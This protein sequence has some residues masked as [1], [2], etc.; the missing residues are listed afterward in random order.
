MGDLIERRDEALEQARSAGTPTI[1]LVQQ[2]LQDAISGRRDLAVAVT[3]A[4]RQADDTPQ[5]LAGKLSSL[6]QLYPD[7]PR[8]AFEAKVSE[9]MSPP[10]AP[11]RRK[12]DYAP[13]P[14]DGQPHAPFA[15]STPGE[16]VMVPTRPPEEKPGPLRDRP[17]QGPVAAAIHSFVQERLRRDDAAFQ[18]L[19][20]PFL[21]VWN[22]RVEPKPEDWSEL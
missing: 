8:D 13:L 5:T 9:L 6:A 4:Y 19:T 2:D 3:T 15:G 22:S 11:P 18:A 21:D 10:N 14:D 20:E 12:P 16:R 7:M 1:A 17:G